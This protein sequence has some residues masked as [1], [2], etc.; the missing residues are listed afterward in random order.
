MK[1]E[2]L[3]DGDYRLLEDESV[4]IDIP[5]SVAS[6]LINIQWRTLTVSAG[7]I[8][9]G[10]SGPTLDTK[11]THRASMFHDA[12][13]K[14]LRKGLLPQARKAT[15]DKLLRDLMIEDRQTPLGYIRAW[16]YYG[17]VRM[18]GAKYCAVTETKEAS[19]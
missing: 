16:Y 11:A 17:F 14:L 6:P 10:A 2:E 3:P 8:W 15:A 7:F 9:D 18:F 4:Q 12:L 1:F 13:Y 5:V 19:D